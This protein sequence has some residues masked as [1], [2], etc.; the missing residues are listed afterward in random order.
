MYLVIYSLPDIL[1]ECL[2]WPV[3]FPFST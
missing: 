1:L 2:G 3:H